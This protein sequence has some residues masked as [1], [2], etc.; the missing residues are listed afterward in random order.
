MPERPTTDIAPRVQRLVDRLV[1]KKLVGSAVVGVRSADEM[2]DVAVAAGHADAAK[3]TAMTIETPYHLA[4]IT[5]MYT[6]TTIM[7]LADSDAIRLEVPIS[8]Y[9]PSDLISNIHVLDGTDHS[10]RITVAQL[11]SQTSG[12]ADYFEGTPNGGSSLVDDLKRGDDRSLSI[13]DIVSIVRQLKPTFVP[14]AG[15]GGKAHYSDTNFAL[16]GAIIEH[17]TG[18]SVATNFE[19]NIFAPLGLSNTFVFDQS[20]TRPTPSAFYFKDQSLDIPLAMS[21]FAP[22]GGVVSTL[23]DSL[24]FLQAFFSAELVTEEQL[25]YMTARWNRIFFPLRYGFGLMKFDLPRWMSPF[26][27]P[28]ELVG[29]SGSTGSFAFYN[30]RRKIHMA[31]T[32]NQMHKPGRPFRLMTQIISIVDEAG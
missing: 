7:K 30:P 11:L 17:V 8:K 20:K 24:R 1:A 2:I 22:D 29:H 10:H 32:V 16:L 9:L 25:V 3:Q 6:A 23:D 21:S 5:K 27:A 31:G 19:K 18:T 15:K 28:P 26:A 12:L 13:E 14:G 4:S